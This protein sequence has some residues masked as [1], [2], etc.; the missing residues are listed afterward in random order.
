MSRVREPIPMQEDDPTLVHTSLSGHKMYKYMGTQLEL[1]G[2][3]LYWLDDDQISTVLAYT[4]DLNART[5]L[6]Q[7]LFGYLYDI[8]RKERNGF[9]IPFHLLD[10]RTRYAL[11]NNLPLAKFLQ[12]KKEEVKPPQ[13]VLLKQRKS[14]AS[15]REAKLT[16][17]RITRQNRKHAGGI[18]DV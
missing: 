1:C 2:M 15:S 5:R 8:R 16:H 10:E 11:E 3:K 17:R 12:V 18:S 6:K 7:W 9:Y 14:L 4:E 13:Q